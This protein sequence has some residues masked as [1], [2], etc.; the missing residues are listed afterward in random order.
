MEASFTWFWRWEEEEG[1]SE[2]SVELLVYSTIEIRVRERETFRTQKRRGI[3]FNR[4]LNVLTF[5]S[6]KKVRDANAF[7][8]V[9][10]FNSYKLTYNG[11]WITNLRYTQRFLFLS[12][13]LLFSLLLCLFSLPSS[14]SSRIFLVQFFH[15]LSVQSE[16]G[17]SKKHLLLANLWFRH[18]AL[19]LF[20][21]RRHARDVQLHLVRVRVPFDVVHVVL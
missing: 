16:K 3:L 18:H 1:G 20:N 14:S 7:C 19:H 8:W 10:F 12:R 21:R 17:A 9:C 13:W 4:I 5:S 6:K 2:F 15:C 11:V